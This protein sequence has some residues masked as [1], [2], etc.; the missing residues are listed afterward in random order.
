[1]ARQ[2][3]MC[4]HPPK[5]KLEVWSKKTENNDFQRTGTAEIERLVIGVFAFIT[6]FRLPCW[7]YHAFLQERIQKSSPRVGKAACAIL[8]GSV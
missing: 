6:S 3:M 1:M 4:F 8:K 5:K 7:W 2:K